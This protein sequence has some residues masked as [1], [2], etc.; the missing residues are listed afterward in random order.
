[1]SEIDFFSETWKSESDLSSVD[2][3]LAA[4][5]VYDADITKA[6]VKTLFWLLDQNHCKAF[7]A[8]EKRCR[9]DSE[10]LIKAPNFDLFL[11]V[12]SEELKDKWKMK[13]I[14]INFCQYFKT[15]ERVE[16]LYLW[17]IETNN[18]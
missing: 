9:I 1:M 11:K 16:T 13:E 3:I 14:N 8:I 5:V 15:Y 12:M 18:K 17:S 2:V 4:D 10:G 6:F 7:I